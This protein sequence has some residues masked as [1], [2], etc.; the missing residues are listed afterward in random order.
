MKEKVNPTFDAPIF[1]SGSM[2]D[3]YEKVYE[4]MR[5]LEEAPKAVREQ[6]EWRLKTVLYAF[7][8]TTWSKKKLPDGNTLPRNEKEQFL[9]ELL[10]DSWPFMGDTGQCADAYA[11]LDGTITYPMIYAQRKKMMHTLR[12]LLPLM[13]LMVRFQNNT[14]PMSVGKLCARVGYTEALEVLWAKTQKELHPFAEQAQLLSSWM[15]SAIQKADHRSLEAVR[16][17]VQELLIH[18][19]PVLKVHGAVFKSVESLLAKGTLYEVYDS[20]L[21]EMLFYDRTQSVTP[22]QDPGD[23]AETLRVALSLIPAKHWCTPMVKEQTGMHQ[24]FCETPIRGLMALALYEDKPWAVPVLI[25]HGLKVPSLEQLLKV[26]R[27]LEKQG[28]S[29]LACATLICEKEKTLL[30]RTVKKESPL[31]GQ[32]RRL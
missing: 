3:K 17:Y 2:V 9:K 21:E 26:R 7:F 28:K 27:Q 16:P 14:A 18:P 19:T 22:E 4:Q 10:A 32:R 6:E 15:Y 25:E 20:P 12:T 13:P 1:L 29:T 23:L 24:V 8:Q 5:I 30:E 31:A 11:R